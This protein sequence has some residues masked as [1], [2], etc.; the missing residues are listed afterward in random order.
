MNL[1]ELMASIK[2]DTSDY[3]RGLSSASGLTKSFG[4]K[5]KLM[6]PKSAKEEYKE[7][8]KEVYEAYEQ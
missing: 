6:T 7:Y 1:F 5:A 2:L 8:L 4:D 3:E